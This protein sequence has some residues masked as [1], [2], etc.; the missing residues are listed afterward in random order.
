[1]INL[2]ALLKE[3]VTLRASDL[4]LKVDAPPV[5][6]IDGE[7]KRSDIGPLDEED[8]VDLA[9]QAL[10]ENQRKTLDSELGIDF[11]LMVPGVARFRGN[12]HTQRGSLAMTFRC[13]PMVIP[14]IAELH[15]PPVLEEIAMKPRGLVLVTG[16]VG[17]GKSTTLA[18]MIDIIN[19][20]KNSKVITI[21]DP[22]EYLHGDKKGFIVQREVGEDT[23]TYAAA[24]RHVLR[25]DPNVILIGEIRDEETM[26]I[27]LTAANTG[28]LVL[29]TLHTIDAMQTVNRVISFYPPHQHKEIRF[30]LAS[31]LQ[32]IISQRLVR[33]AKSNGRVPAAEILICTAAIKD[34]IIEPEK[35]S[36]IRTA[37]QEGFTE[38][39]M[40]TFDQ[41][42]M[43]LYKEEMISFEDALAHASNPSEFD[44]RVR[45]IEATSDKTWNV[46]EGRD[47]AIVTGS[48]PNAPR[49]RS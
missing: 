23:P 48:G 40:Q 42:L 32:A 17:S 26:S 46:F 7:L 12:I 11:A 45:G 31:S 33:R 19:E 49:S 43:R 38:Y 21:E 13:V 8:L 20:K 9:S 3:M 44:L 14:T 34:Y 10:D 37:I 28:H 2:N 29:T 35:T 36:L 22:I 30:L 18:A 15:M 6:R 1:M 39:G 27:A 25:Q 47:S 41:S 5:F 24:L 16:T 4:H